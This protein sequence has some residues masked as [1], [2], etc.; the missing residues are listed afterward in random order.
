MLNLTNSTRR[1]LTSKTLNHVLLG[2]ITLGA[3]LVLFPERSE[4]R[5][6]VSA[7]IGNT[8]V[9]YHSEGGHGGHDQPYNRNV[10]VRQNGRKRHVERVRTNNRCEIGSEREYRRNSRRMV[11]VWIPGHYETKIKRNGREK[12]RWVSG[13]W[14]WVKKGTWY[15][16]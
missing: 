3:L 16:S 12:T 5:I 11:E 1:P 6:R 2:A 15:S 4:A 13:R 7:R 8:S 14:E 9:G 10:K